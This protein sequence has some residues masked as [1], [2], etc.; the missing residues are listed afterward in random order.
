MIDPG[1]ISFLMEPE[2][3][4]VTSRHGHLFLFYQVWPAVDYEC[5]WL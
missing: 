1:K 4:F 2:T 5:F 3:E